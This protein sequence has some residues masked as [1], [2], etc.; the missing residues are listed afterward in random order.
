MLLEYLRLEDTPEDL[1]RLSTGPACGRRTSTRKNPKGL[2]EVDRAGP[3]ARKLKW[4]KVS[5]A[6]ELDSR[7]LPGKY[8]TV[9]PIY[10]AELIDGGQGDSLR[11]GPAVERPA[12]DVQLLAHLGD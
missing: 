1:L 7:D 6:D 5:G 11:H 8:L 3:C 4:S 10:G 2:I 9:I 12:A